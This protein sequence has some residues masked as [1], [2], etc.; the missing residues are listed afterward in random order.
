MNE[1]KY[2]ILREYI[3]RIR[4]KSF[5][6][7]SLLGPFFFSLLFLLPAYFA[8][9]SNDKENKIG[10]I[11]ATG[12]LSKNTIS[13]DCK[14]EFLS[15]SDTANINK[16]ISNNSYYGIIQVP[17][18]DSLRR[19]KVRYFFNKQP[20]IFLLNSFEHSIEKVVLEKQLTNYGVKSISTMMDSIKSIT[21]ITAL[22]IGKGSEKEVNPR[23]LS[24]LSMILGLAIYL[25]VFL[26]SVQVMRGVLEEKSN[27]IIELII[28][29]VD[30]FKFMVG[31]ITGVAMVGLTQLIIWILLTYGVLSIFAGGNDLQSGNSV[32]GFLNQRIDQQQLNQLLNTVNSIDFHIIIPTFI[33]FFI[34][35]YLLYSSMFAAIGSIVNHDDEVQQ[36]STIISIPLIIAIFVLS[37]TT[38]NPDSPLSFWF[39]MIPFTSPVVMM[40][41]IVHGVPIEQLLISACVLILTIIGFMWLSSKIYVTAILMYGKKITLKEILKWFKS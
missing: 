28:S 36:L 14:V 1:I 21:R 3:T 10:I 32:S 29:S 34:A 6:L 26:F 23:L 17:Q 18:I 24:S 38:N 27:R 19:Q 35:G 5:I 40:G 25:Y 2:I 41:R 11:D 9:Y 15:I 8:K 12:L 30:P 31:K 39:S 16:L 7:L 4:K 33:F 13:S 20:S 37:S 22:K